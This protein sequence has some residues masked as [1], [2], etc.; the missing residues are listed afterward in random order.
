M[1]SHEVEFLIFNITFHILYCLNLKQL[2]K[3]NVN[4]TKISHDTK[5]P[6]GQSSC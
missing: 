6:G 4:V 3:F 2:F 5:L 1:M